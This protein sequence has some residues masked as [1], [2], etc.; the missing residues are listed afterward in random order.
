MKLKEV[1]TQTLKECPLEDISKHLEKHN[2]QLHEAIMEAK[3]E[4]LL[5]AAADAEDEFYQAQ[6]QYV[7]AYEDIRAKGFILS[8]QRMKKLQHDLSIAEGILNSVIA[9]KTNT[10]R[11]LKE[12]T[13]KMLGRIGELEQRIK[14]RQCEVDKLREELELMISEKEALHNG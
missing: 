9:E 14:L 13:S 10:S 4:M 6:E 3:K 5:F 7:K 1:Y 8:T 2:K 11:N 12:I